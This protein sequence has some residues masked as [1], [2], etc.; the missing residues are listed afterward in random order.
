MRRQFV[1]ATVMVAIMVLVVLMVLSVMS[2]LS[3]EEMNAGQT[4]RSYV[5][6]DMTGD[7]INDVLV[8]VKSFDEDIP[9]EIRAVNGKTGVE[10]WQKKYRN[11]L[12]YTHPAG[13]LNGDNKPDVVIVLRSCVDVSSGKGYGKVIG[14]DGFNGNEL[15][16]QHKEGEMGV[17]MTANPAN[18]TSTSRTD[19]VVNTITYTTYGPR[20]SVMAI[21]GC[22]GE[23]LWETPSTDN[24]V[25]GVP[26]DLTDDRKDE[27]V[28]GMPEEMVIPEGIIAT[29]TDVI[30]AE[31]SNYK[32][33]IWKYP[34]VATS[35]LAT[36]D[37]A[38]DLNDD[39]VNDLIVWTGCC[40]LAA[41]S[42][43]GDKLW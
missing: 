34:D 16:N 39:E 40:K 23:K 7:S 27:V 13:D 15:W 4:D 31:G 21:N 37:P 10:L 33:I 11:C 17:W 26:V 41:L 35:D 2:S 22:N 30:V 1:I 42:G 12:V 3:A 18:L 43:N 6:C 25:F 38:G 32:E 14:V 19:V 5:Y 20:T 9:T 29:A 36:F 8:R 28:M 24:I